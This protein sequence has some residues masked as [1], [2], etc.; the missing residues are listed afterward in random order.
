[1]TLEIY[2]HCIF[3]FPPS[4]L[5]SFPSEKQERYIGEIM[6]LR[7]LSQQA[8]DPVVMTS[9]ITNEQGTLTVPTHSLGQPLACAARSCHITLL[10]R[11]HGHFDS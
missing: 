10:S 6:C 4:F 5:N 11:L 8:Y 9:V 1:M 7:N 3:T 2:F